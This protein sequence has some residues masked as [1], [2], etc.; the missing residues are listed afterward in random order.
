M[1]DEVRELLI[2]EGGREDVHVVM[3]G[4]TDSSTTTHKLKTSSISSGGYSALCSNF[5][6]WRAATPS[7]GNPAHALLLHS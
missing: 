3:M 6:Q 2:L 1:S 4:A 7:P 5:S